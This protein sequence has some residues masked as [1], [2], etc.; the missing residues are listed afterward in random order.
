[1]DT[2]DINLHLYLLLGIRPQLV[3]LVTRY[4]LQQV[5]LVTSLHLHLVTLVTKLLHQQGVILVSRPHQHLV[6]MATNLHL[7]SDPEQC[8]I[9]VLD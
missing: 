8:S 9:C 6:T 3:T 2:Q 1:M 5:T 7:L 4:H